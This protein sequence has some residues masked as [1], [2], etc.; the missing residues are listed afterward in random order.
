ML[1]EN[2]CCFV[3]LCS[4]FAFASS[5]P[6]VSDFQFFYDT[7]VKY[8]GSECKTTSGLNGICQSVQNCE[9][10]NIKVSKNDF[11]SFSNVGPLYCCTTD[12]SG[13]TEP[14]NLVEN[15]QSD[16]LLSL[17]PIE[18]SKSCCYIIQ[19]SILLNNFSLL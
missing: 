10:T 8:E 14:T 7:N 2:F 17:R 3:I 19:L 13:A 9:K 6:Q 4:I 12:T 16:K 5:R 15:K 18:Q 1:F 11:C